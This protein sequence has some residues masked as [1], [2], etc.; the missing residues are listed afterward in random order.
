[1][2][3]SA[4]GI[5]R[6]RFYLVAARK[7]GGGPKQ[8]SCKC[9]HGPGAGNGSVVMP[10]WPCRSY[11][12]A[13]MSCGRD[14]WKTPAFP[15]DRP[16]MAEVLVNGRVL[17]ISA[18]AAR[19]DASVSITQLQPNG[20]DGGRVWTTSL[21]RPSASRRQCALVVC[22]RRNA[23]TRESRIHQANPYCRCHAREHGADAGGE[24]VSPKRHR[25]QGG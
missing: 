16:D 1:M 15:V 14:R 7:H 17:A 8:F 25:A 10:S 24:R 3:R 21:V 23:T 20:V 22:R 11:R 18:R 9:R 5:P 12:R 19:L 4:T 13:R 6:E 2:T